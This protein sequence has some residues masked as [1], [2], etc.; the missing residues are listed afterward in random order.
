MKKSL[1]KTDKK[2]RIFTKVGKTTTSQITKKPLNSTPSMRLG[3]RPGML[4]SIFIAV[5][6]AF[7]IQLI[8][9]NNLAVRGGE[10]KKLE[11][12]KAELLHD[13][14]VLDDSINQLR[15]ISRIQ[16]VAEGYGMAFRNDSFD[17]LP[18]ASE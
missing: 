11:L 1:F 3:R 2:L 16:I 15:S 10:I 8:I 13:I 14:Q 6:S 9:A 7:F 17:Y 5:F 12:Q 4:V 18:Q